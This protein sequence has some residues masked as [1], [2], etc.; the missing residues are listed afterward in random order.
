MSPARLLL[1]AAALPLAVAVPAGAG[2][3][4]EAQIGLAVTSS[5]CGL[6][7]GD[8]V[9]FFVAARGMVGV[10]QVKM[11]LSWQPGDAISGVSGGTA[12]L[13]ADHAFLSPGPPLVTDNHA[14]FGMATFGAGIDGEGILA[15]FALTLAPGMTAAV[16]MEVRLDMVSLGRSSADRDTVVAPGA[17]V[18]ANYCDDNG[19]PVAR[20]M[21]LRPPRATAEFSTATTA[22][23][24][25]HSPGEMMLGAQL[26]DNGDLRAYQTISWTLDN[27]GN[28]RVWVLTAQGPLAIEPGDQLEGG[29]RTDRLGDTY[30]VVDASPGELFGDGVLEVTACGELDGQTYCDQST[31]RWLA[32]SPTAVADLGRPQPTVAT[33]VPNFPNPFNATTVIPIDLTAAGARRLQVEIRDLLGRTVVRLHDGPAAAGRVELRWDGRD[34][35]GRVAASGVYLCHAQTEQWQAV[36]PL[37]LAR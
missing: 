19:Q 13:A 36:R 26:L 31:F 21:F 3:N 7:E 29:S 2:A 14:E 12:G 6:Q 27:R 32:G 15:H 28:S 22:N 25:D 24:Q 4:A 23:Q 9:D 10:R 11:L 18:L 17:V 34:A 16:P 1:L 20:G 37:T 35:D 30:L 8:L 5:P 33:L